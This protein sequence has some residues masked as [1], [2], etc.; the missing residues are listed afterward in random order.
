MLFLPKA[1]LKLR[2]PIKE[3]LLEDNPPKYKET[4]FADY[5]D[6]PKYKETTFADYE[7]HFIAKWQDGTSAL[8]HFKIWTKKC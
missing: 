3:L 6:P 4:T 1:S 2:G 5:E 8:T 7:A